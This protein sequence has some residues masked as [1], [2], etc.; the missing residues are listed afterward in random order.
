VLLR[1]GLEL[2]VALLVA[3]A[4]QELID[5]VDVARDDAGGVG[6]QRCNSASTIVS[7]S[8]KYSGWPKTVVAQNVAQSDSTVPAG[9]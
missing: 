8:T 5:V 3:T 7:S 1:R 9:I 6:D 4:L 2:L